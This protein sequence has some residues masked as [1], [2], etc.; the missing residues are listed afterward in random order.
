VTG[1][2]A[3]IIANCKKYWD[4]ANGVGA[5]ALRKTTAHSLVEF[6][7]DAVA[8]DAE[9]DNVKIRVCTPAHL[10][11]FMCHEYLIR[12]AISELLSNAVESSASAMHT[13]R[14]SGDVL[15]DVRTEDK[16]TAR[17][18][19]FEV[20]DDGP[21]WSAELKRLLTPGPFYEY[22]DEP[23]ATASAGF[24]LAGIA[25]QEHGGWLSHDEAAGRN[26]IRLT[27]PILAEWDRF[28]NSQELAHVM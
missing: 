19:E 13:N 11:V 15:I 8:P 26:L 23:R 5:G 10:P 20:S 9:R 17:Y 3:R 1:A 12:H 21:P 6:A 18:I 14:T 2:H 25:A 7:V 27:L 16:G 28:S 22:G 4:Y 24:L